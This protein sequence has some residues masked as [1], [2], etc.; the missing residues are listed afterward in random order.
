MSRPLRIEIS[1]GLYHVASRGLERRAIGEGYGGLKE[2]AVSNIVR[3]VASADLPR[4]C[5]L[6]RRMAR[7]EES[8]GKGS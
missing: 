6:R 3:A 5:A 2:A 4:R 7:I 8:L 1:D